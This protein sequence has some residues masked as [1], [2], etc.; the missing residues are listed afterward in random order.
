MSAGMAH[1]AGLIEGGMSHRDAV[2]QVGCANSWGYTHP[3]VGRS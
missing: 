3:F 2:A 1:L